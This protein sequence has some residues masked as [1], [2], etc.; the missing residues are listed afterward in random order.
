[1]IEPKIFYR[2]LDSI[3]NKIGKDKSRQEYL[4]DLAD[5]LEKVFGDDLRIGKVESSIYWCRCA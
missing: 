1:M 3:Q 5:E 2:K 4:F